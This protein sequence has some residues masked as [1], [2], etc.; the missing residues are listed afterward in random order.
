MTLVA[1]LL[2]LSL[3]LNSNTGT[4][5]AYAVDEPDIVITTADELMDFA[6]KVNTTATYAAYST[7]YVVLDADIDLSG[8]QW[9]PIANNGS[10]FKG[11]FDGRGHTIS[12]IDITLDSLASRTAH[13]VY[14]SGLF[15]WVAAS[16][17]SVEGKTAIRNFVLQGAYTYEGWF[18]TYYS[19][20]GGIAGYVTTE[21]SSGSLLIENVGNEVDITASDVPANSQYQF[22]G[23]VAGGNL[24]N[25]N[26]SYEIS[27]CYNAGDITVTT[28][29]PGG[30]SVHSSGVGGIIGP[31]QG[32]NSSAAAVSH[33]VSNCYNVGDLTS[34]G[35]VGGIVGMVGI[36]P[37]DMP[38]TVSNC[39]NAGALTTDIAF[40]E[41]P[42]SPSLPGIPA[43]YPLPN[44]YILTITPTEDMFIGGIAANYTVPRLSAYL[45][46]TPGMTFS[47]N[48][49]L[50]QA[51]PTLSGSNDDPTEL[52]GTG[53]I[54]IQNKNTDDPPNTALS[55]LI[56]P[57]NTNNTEQTAAELSAAALVTTLNGLQSPEPW[58]EGNL[59]PA[60]SWQNGSASVAGPLGKAI[61]TDQP[62]GNH[63]DQNATQPPELSVTAE[64]PD[65]VKLSDGSVTTVTWYKV[66]EPSDTVVNTTTVS[67]TQTEV[68]DSYTPDVT[69][70][71]DNYYYAVVTTSWDSSAE[72]ETQA[73]AAVR[74]RVT[75]ATRSAGIPDITNQPQSVAYPQKTTDPHDVSIEVTTATGAT[76]VDANSTLTYQWYR[77]IDGETNT[78]GEAIKGATTTSY[79]PST[80]YG[81][82]YFYCVIT[83]TVDEVKQESVTSAVATITMEPQQIGT[84]EELLAF[85]QTIN[86]SPTAGTAFKGMGVEL[87]DDIDLA[88]IEWVPIAGYRAA[89]GGLNAGQVTF[90]GTF[91]GNGHTIRNL[92]YVNSSASNVGGFIGQVGGGVVIENLVVQGDISVAS[93][94]GTGGIV[95]NVNFGYNDVDNVVIRNVGSE[96]TITSS[97]TSALKLGGVLGAS[98]MS[99]STPQLRIEN[100][101]FSGQI[102][103]QQ[104]GLT[105]AI[106]GI[107]GY[108][109]TTQNNLEPVNFITNCYNLGRIEGIGALGGIVGTNNYYQWAPT[110]YAAFFRIQ[111]CYNA[112][113]IIDWSA[114]QGKVGSIAGTS[115][116][117]VTTATFLERNYYLGYED[118]IANAG[119][120]EDPN[121]VSQSEAQLS[122]A[123]FIGT[124]NA[125]TN[126]GAYAEGSIYPVLAW[127]KTGALGVPMF[128]TQLVSGHADRDTTPDTL[129]ITAAAPEGT[130][131]ASTNGRI[132]KLVW[133]VNNTPSTQG[134]TAVRTYEPSG[135]E[136]ATT[137]TDSFTPPTDTLGDTYYY[138][139][140]TNTWTGAGAASSEATSA[141]A[142]FRV[143][144]P[145]KIAVKPEITAG[146]ED[147]IFE[148]A[149]TPE[150]L[151]VSVETP[152][153]GGVL[154]YQWYVNSIE[155]TVGAQILNK[156]TNT[157]LAPSTLYGD[158]FYFCVVTNTVEGV[159]H[160]ESTSRI[161]AVHVTGYEI[162]T[163]VDLYNLRA[164]ANNPNSG[165][166]DSF[167]NK[168]VLLMNDIDLSTFDGTRNWTEPIIGGPWGFQG[169]F[170]GQG[171]AIN[172]FNISGDLGTSQNCG[173][174]AS[175]PNVIIKN[176]ILRGSIDVVLTAPGLNYDTMHVAPLCTYNG[177]RIE[178]CGVEVDIAVRFLVSTGN[179]SGITHNGTITGSYYKGDIVIEG[180]VR[181]AGLLSARGRGSNNYAVGSITYN[182]PNGYR[183]SQGGIGG[184]FG[185]DSS[186]GGTDSHYN[187][188]DASIAITNAEV[189]LNP[190]AQ[191]IS[192]NTGVGYLRAA[193]FCVNPV[194]ANTSTNNYFLADSLSCAGTDTA[195]N[196]SFDASAAEAVSREVMRSDAF[197][198]SLNAAPG[199]DY[200]VA[201]AGSTPRLYWEGTLTAT[202]RSALNA[203]A[204]EAATLIADTEVA[205]SGENIPVGQYW[206]AQAAL[207][208][209]AAALAQAQSV[210]AQPYLTQ[211]QIEDA[212]AAL[213]DATDA[214]IAAREPGS[215]I[216]Y[217]PDEAW[218]RLAGSDRYTAMDSIVR[219]GWSTANTVIVA[220][221]ENWPD[222]L[223]ASSLAGIYDAPVILTASNALTPVSE[224][225]IDDLLVEQV[226]IVG[227]PAS[228]SP[229]V[230]SSLRGIAPR[231]TR[232]ADA[233]R[234]LTALK[235]YE[236]GI[237][238]WSTTA[239]IAS[240]AG[241]SDALSVSPMA[242]AEKMP[243][244]L[245]DRANGLDQATTQ[246]IQAGGFSDII[247][248][249]GPASVPEGIKDQLGT[250]FN[251]TRLGGEDRYEASTTIAD[252]TVTNSTYLGYH[253]LCV[254]TGSNYPDALAG[255][256]FAGHTGG[257]LLLVDTSQSG[258]RAVEVVATHKLDIGK[259]YF[260]GGTASVPQSLADLFPQA[261][262][263]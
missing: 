256:A 237:G 186:S 140:A 189:N 197:L 104:S 209:Y 235:V 246:A 79:T 33:V 121:N 35:Y 36:A 260:L 190:D 102:S 129:S 70:V 229:A 154:S 5:K 223:A 243:I 232:L 119:A 112:G 128:T 194:A 100:S 56:S 177:G 19:V 167:E 259:G 228:V 222:A 230:E 200:F 158:Y 132:T 18:P 30:S 92:S 155:S 28:E 88:G 242:F 217:P 65:Y 14:G 74:Y 83:H 203:E 218:P 13:G 253:G 215:F 131:D 166:S 214:F 89:G 181:S 171:Y 261:A 64:L 172:G 168:T 27:N 46:L 226:Y 45:S 233:D 55:N 153:H 174:F 11:I 85:V 57:E 62:Q 216:Y 122:D 126:T 130:K 118:A 107:A 51:G 169:T 103:A 161:A 42:Y 163:P 136:L 15:S 48:Y 31:I 144:E 116:V 159:K 182:G 245:A 12:N 212:R 34:P 41:P 185:V 141:P 52:Q 199:F 244:F 10:P 250:S 208:T 81:T 241:Y 134:G 111:G 25:I 123:G 188:V 219:A 206:V 227:G 142:R 127:Q 180:D 96:V 68:T 234:F 147:M 196:P 21:G 8:R 32:P 258:M 106:G 78:G 254:A 175:S 156:E 173:L 7:K 86:Q 202:D 114:T 87:L 66:G 149:T 138:V 263:N 9:I 90:C 101:Y 2:S 152:P 91:N 124:I 29:A 145:Q 164:I 49:Y 3:S 220:T 77:A 183:A 170:D 221:G 151:R 69:T 37:T 60:L 146:P 6:E 198:A 252:H 225:L 236:E 248:V 184:A 257:V 120:A 93:T 67:G 105:S 110:P 23:I 211:S 44:W 43:N 63:A 97:S 109:D 125:V 53:S 84:L 71:G 54:P 179:V 187:Y 137:F 135:A 59:Y 47:N 20:I 26:Y 205:S 115:T 192:D 133:Y 207:D 58:I 176:L 76:A 108:I 39:Y 95:G 255:G 24:S 80:D 61:I 50:E 139:V 82:Y 113:Q 162:R 224:K 231:V 178:N 38:V 213:Q 240:A 17:A 117:G 16:S 94:G 251:Y 201:N 247:I 143:T 193:G 4:L 1:L 191:W 157:T 210:L 239:I 148:Q 99:A 262:T 73:T 72:T 98:F 204:S 22:A 160:D 238:S 40:A 165:L 195:Q 75:D 249:G 150:P